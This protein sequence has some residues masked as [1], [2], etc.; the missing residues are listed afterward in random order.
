MI[1]VPK[2]Y[3]VWKAS[4]MSGNLRSECLKTLIAQYF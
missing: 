4:V 3:F 2:K 1:L